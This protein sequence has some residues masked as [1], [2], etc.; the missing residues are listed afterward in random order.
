LKGSKKITL[1]KPGKDPIFPKKF[2]TNK[3]LVH[4]GQ[5]IRE[6]HPK[7]SPKASGL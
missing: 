4:N 2:E 7:N 1:P 6:S 3:P 5:I